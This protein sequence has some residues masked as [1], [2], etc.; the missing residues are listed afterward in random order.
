MLNRH[1]TT[2]DLVSLIWKVVADLE[3]VNCIVGDH[4]DVVVG[5]DSEVFDFHVEG[6]EMVNHDIFSSALTDSAPAMTL[7]GL[8]DRI[9][10]AATV[11]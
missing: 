8:G 5:G 7:R 2:I 10:H 6:A 3:S 11:G 4:V 9:G 1:C